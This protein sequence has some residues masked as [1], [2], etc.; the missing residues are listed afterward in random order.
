LF[1]S[2]TQKSKEKLFRGTQP[3]STLNSDLD[4]IVEKLNAGLGPLLA[5]VQETGS[6]KNESAKRYLEAKSQIRK[7]IKQRDYW[8]EGMTHPNEFRKFYLADD[9]S[10]CGFGTN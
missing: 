2:H 1:Q 3:G 6:S 4:N 8:P 9:M 5:T 10:Y 7:D